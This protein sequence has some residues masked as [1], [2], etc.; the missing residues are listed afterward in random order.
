MMKKSIIQD[1]TFTFAVRIVRC[2]RSMQTMQR[3]FVLANQLLRSWTSIGANVEEALGA[4]S[5]RDLVADRTTN[6]SEL[7]TQNS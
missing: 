4:Q 2:I 5:R 6:N 1:K 3:E 7:I